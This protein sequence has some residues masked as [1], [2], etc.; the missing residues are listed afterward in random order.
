[1]GDRH[2]DVIE[3]YIYVGAKYKY[4]YMG[5]RHDVDDQRHMTNKDPR[6]YNDAQKAVLEAHFQ[7]VMCVCVC[8]CVY[9]YMQPFLAPDG[10]AL[11]GS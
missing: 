6:S 11:S 3:V 7:A 4:I 10:S 1:M 5:D 8:V 9:T 2:D